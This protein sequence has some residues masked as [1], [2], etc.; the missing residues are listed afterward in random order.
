[1]RTRRWLCVALMGGT[2]G[3]AQ[4]AQAERR[5][6]RRLNSAESILAGTAG[7]NASAPGAP[8]DQA[9]LV[10][11]RRQANP[12]PRSRHGT[13]SAFNGSR[14]GTRNH[15]DA[16][17]DLSGANTLGK[18]NLLIAAINAMLP[19]VS[20]RKTQRKG[21]SDAI[22]KAA[23]ALSR[24]LAGSPDEWLLGAVEHQED[25][26]DPT[27]PT[28]GATLDR[29]A[30]GRVDDPIELWKATIW[31]GGGLLTTGVIHQL[32]DPGSNPLPPPSGGRRSTSDELYVLG[33]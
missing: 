26:D 28:L 17:R 24:A 12:T 9:D 4:L 23:D 6:G 27:A 16:S 18:V 30:A 2:L 32:A 19:S 15:H 33:Y 5:T 7:S 21:T 25:V 3:F 11:A 1:M 13:P 20:A 22:A 14:R 10:A 31:L 29:L 8:A